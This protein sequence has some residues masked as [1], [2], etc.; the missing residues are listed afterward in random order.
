MEQIPQLADV[1]SQVAIVAIFIWY[2][3]SRNGKQEKVLERLHKAQEAH[4][5][6]LRQVAISHGL[7]KDDLSWLD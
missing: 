3:K 6:I 4:T 5:N 1:G 7:K 2:M